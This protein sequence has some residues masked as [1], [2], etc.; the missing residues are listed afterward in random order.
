MKNAAVNVIHEQSLESRSFYDA[1]HDEC[2][3][4][5]LNKLRVLK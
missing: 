2:A 1:Y 3:L 5:A 4:D